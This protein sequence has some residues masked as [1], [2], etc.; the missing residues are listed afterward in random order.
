MNNN[1]KKTSFDLTIKNFEILEEFSKKT[2]LKYTTIVNTLIE[3]TLGKNN[4]INA[5]MNIVLQDYEE[6]TKIIKDKIAAETDIKKIDELIEQW[7]TV[8]KNYEKPLKIFL[9]ENQ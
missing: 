5:I 3:Y 7:N 4:S 1:T 6:N 8:R 2:G 9:P